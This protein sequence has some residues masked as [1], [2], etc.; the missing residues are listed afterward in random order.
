[1]AGVGLD[2]RIVLHIN[3]EVRNF[4]CIVL[5]VACVSGYSNYRVRPVR[6]SVYQHYINKYRGYSGYQKQRPY[7]KSLG[8][9]FGRDVYL[10]R[11]LPR[12]RNGYQKGDQYYRKGVGPDENVSYVNSII[13]FSFV[14]LLFIIIIII[15]TF[16][17]ICFYCPLLL[18][19]D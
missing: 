3:M 10:Q 18:T 4:I 11:S 6:R 8:Q 9:F 15:F 7:F 17:L 5:S 16:Y 19:H 1:V 13:V 2:V 12:Y 14:V